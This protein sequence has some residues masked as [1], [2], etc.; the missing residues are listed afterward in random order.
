ML[1]KL[2]ASSLIL[3]RQ[4]AQT[5]M[6]RQKNSIMLTN[7][8]PKLPMRDKNATKDFYLN[9]LGFTKL[10]DYGDYLMIKKDRTFHVLNIRNPG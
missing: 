8:H 6:Y 9:K 10:D 4:F 1:A 2:K 5:L 3:L 7:I